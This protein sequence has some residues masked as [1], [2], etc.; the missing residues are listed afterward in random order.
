MVCG[1]RVILSEVRKHE[2]EGSNAVSGVWCVVHGLRVILSKVRKHEVEGSREV[3]G[4]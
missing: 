1:L 3:V 4:D 2:V